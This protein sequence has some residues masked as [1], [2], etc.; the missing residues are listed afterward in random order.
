MLTALSAHACHT[1]L[2]AR[3][4]KRKECDRSISH[5]DPG[6]PSPPGRI[7]LI[8]S[9]LTSLQIDVYDMFNQAVSCATATL[10]IEND[11]KYTWAP[12]TCC[13]ATDYCTTGGKSGFPGARMSSYETH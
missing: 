12:A 3:C 2:G 6:P 5:H 8:V 4:G 9:P 1:L 10:R 11:H 13:N 7:P